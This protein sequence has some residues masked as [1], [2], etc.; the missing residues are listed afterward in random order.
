MFMTFLLGLRIDLDLKFI[1][2]CL[3]Y[4]KIKFKIN[5]IFTCET[6]K[7]TIFDFI[8]IKHESVEFM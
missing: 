8:T 5:Q 3:S 2:M 7:T 4:R 6:S 1:K